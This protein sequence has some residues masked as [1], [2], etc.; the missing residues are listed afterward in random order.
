MALAF[1]SSFVM[2]LPLAGCGTDGPTMGKV[3]GKVLYKDGS[4]P[5]GG[6]VVIRFEPAPGTNAEIRKAASC[7]IMEDGTYDL[8]TVKPG[9]GAIF[10]TYKVVFTILESYRTG[11]SLVDEKYTKAE[12]TPFERVIDSSSHQFDFEI[13]RAKGK[14]KQ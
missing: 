3:T 6:E 1:L 2:L 14:R 10:G 4:V 7:M 5:T 13:E 11:V 12:T 9:D 8:L